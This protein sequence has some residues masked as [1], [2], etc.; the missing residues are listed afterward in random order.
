MVGMDK[1]LPEVEAEKFRK[2]YDPKRAHCVCGRDLSKE[3]ISYYVPHEAGWSID[4]EEEKAWL[5]V[6]CTCGYDMSIWKI[7]ARAR[8]VIS[9][10]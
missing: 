6:H 9:H 3:P 7:R 5:F 1:I 2:L 10:A 8:M 4:C